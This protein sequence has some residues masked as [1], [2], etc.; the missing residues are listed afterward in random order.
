MTAR[1]L[2]WL[3]VVLG[4]SAASAADLPPPMLNALEQAHIPLANV[5]IEVREVNARSPLFS[6]NADRAMNPASV[7]KLLTTYAAL[8]RLGPAYTWKTEARLAGELDAEGV[9]HGDLILKG[10]GDPN[11][12]EEQFWLWLRELRNRGLREIRGDLV[13]DRSAFELPPFDPA[14]FD[15]TPLAPYNA[16]AE[17]LV[18]NGSVLTLRLLPRA[19]SVQVLDEPRLAG[20]ALD[21]RLRLTARPGCGAN[22]DDGIRATVAQGRLTLVGDYPAACGE[23]NF[24]LSPLPH[25]DYVYALFR[26]LWQ[27]LGGTLSGGLRDGTAPA[28]ATLLSSHESAPLGELIRATNKFSNNLMARQLYLTLGLSEAAPAT[29]ER[30]RAAIADWLKSHQ[31][32]FPE[33]VIEN[34]AGLSRRE[35]ISAR[36]LAD[37][38]QWASASRF[39]PEFESSLAIVGLDGTLRR[40]YRERAFAGHAHLKS[41][42]LDEARSLAGYLQSRSGRQWL[43]AIMVNQPGAAAAQPAFDAL[44]EWLYQQ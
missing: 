12:S 1:W 10:Y 43:L 16:G 9:L 21:N 39:Q 32:D 18:V 7:M 22:W 41:G 17:A 20:L 13:L 8:D 4:V 31:A 40:R 29:P 27:E 42:S 15:N 28:T 11:F 6:H 38:L 2:S 14:A 19:T 24:Y 25:R 36:H 37:L 35:R 30:S 44:L 5:A 34:G 26:N 33:L 3:V 23:R